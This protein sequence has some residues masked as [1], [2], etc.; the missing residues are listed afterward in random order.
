MLCGC[1]CWLCA[2]KMVLLLMCAGSSQTSNNSYEAPVLPP[3][4]S[5]LEPCAHRPSLIRGSRSTWQRVDKYCC[6]SFVAGE[7]KNR[8]IK[9]KITC[10]QEEVRV[11]K[12]GLFPQKAPLSA[13]TIR[14]GLALIRCLLL[15]LE[16]GQQ[17]SWPA[18]TDLGLCSV[19][20]GASSPGEGVEAVLG[21]RGLY[22]QTDRASVP[23]RA[24]T[25]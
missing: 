22:R 14:A 13:F 4:Q 8:A 11:V 9:G 12:T 2:A 25:R 24:G 10:S 6:P 18:V 15:L 20:L 1:H 3:V 19:F 17:L 21:A 23:A 5:T 16:K 7:T